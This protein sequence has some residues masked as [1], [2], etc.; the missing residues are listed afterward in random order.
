[1]KVYQLHESGGQWEDYFDYIVGTYLDKQ[2]A[3]IKQ[4]ELEAQEIIDRKCDNCLL[5]HCPFDC[6]MDC[7]D[8]TKDTMIERAMKDCNRCDAIKT[9]DVNSPDGYCVSCKNQSLHCEDKYFRIE[10]V[11]VIE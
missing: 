9:E 3:E 8:C 1:M 11:D 4:K 6:D 5:Y 2:K 10:E 7:E